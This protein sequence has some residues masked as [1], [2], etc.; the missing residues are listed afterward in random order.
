[1]RSGGGAALQESQIVAFFATINNRLLISLATHA[2]EL[3]NSS[4]RSN[5]HPWRSSCERGAL[6]AAAPPSSWCP[7]VNA[8]LLSQSQLTSADADFLVRIGQARPP[9]PAGR[10]AYC[11]AP[12]LTVGPTPDQRAPACVPRRLPSPAGPF[13]ICF[14]RPDLADAVSVGRAQS[15]GIRVTK[16]ALIE[17]FPCLP[18]F[19]W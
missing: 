11:P 1:V 16:P 8:R 7:Q 2:S 18:P 14:E 19:L 12:R 3:Q 15:F 5:A 13:A 9:A 4:V 6:R 17:W 10:N